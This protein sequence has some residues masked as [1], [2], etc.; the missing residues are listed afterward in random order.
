MTDSKDL[1]KKFDVMIPYLGSEVHFF[2]EIFRDGSIVRNSFESGQL[3]LRNVYIDDETNTPKFLY[4]RTF[5][6]NTALFPFRRIASSGYEF[7]MID[8]WK[9]NTIWI[10][11]DTTRLEKLFHIDIDD[12]ESLPIVLHPGDCC[13]ERN[14]SYESHAI[15][16]DIDYYERGCHPLF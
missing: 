12:R 1:H 7:R 16:H 11:N 9:S 14:V 5:L 6:N 15:I 4:G 2:F 3:Y 13:M 8:I 10:T